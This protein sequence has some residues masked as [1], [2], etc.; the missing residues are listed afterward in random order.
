ME[1][2]IHLPRRLIEDLDLLIQAGLY[3]SREEALEAA[4][5]H[6]LRRLQ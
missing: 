6:L 3:R 5:K 1:T 4:I 2:V